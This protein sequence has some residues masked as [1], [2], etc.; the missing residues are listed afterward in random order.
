MNTKF[1]KKPVVI[2]AFQMTKERRA[3]NADWPDWLHEAWQKDHEETGSLYPADL[4]K[5]D[6]SALS[7]RTLGGDH[8]V[9]WG[10]WI[11]RGAKGELYA[12]KDDIF[13]LTY[14]EVT[15]AHHRRE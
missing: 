4:G 10:D 14:E 5:A 9:S 2:E 1:R 3:S 13:K 15:N 7:I 11:I 12:C 8:L 6:T